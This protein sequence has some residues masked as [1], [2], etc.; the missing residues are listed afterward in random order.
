MCVSEHKYV[1]E[2][3]RVC[4]CMDVGVFK[5]V[6]VHRKKYARK[7]SC[8]HLGKNSSQRSG[9]FSCHYLFNQHSIDFRLIK[10]FIVIRRD[11]LLFIDG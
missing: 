2:R 4:V 8:A 5:C 3:V 10:S 7:T 9:L 11:W 1:C 6:S